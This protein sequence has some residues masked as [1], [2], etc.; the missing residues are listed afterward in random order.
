MMMKVAKGTTYT[1]LGSVVLGLEGAEQSLLSTKNLDG[2]TGR[3]GKV[4]E[5]SSVRNEAR[6]NQLADERS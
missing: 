6:T 5:R 1:I 2:R 3:L 4:H